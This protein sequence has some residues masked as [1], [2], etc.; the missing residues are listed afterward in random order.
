MSEDQQTTDNDSDDNG[1][2]DAMSAVAIV[3][4][5]VV[6]IIYWLSGM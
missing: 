4:F 3:L 2:V 1:F 6:T 5:P